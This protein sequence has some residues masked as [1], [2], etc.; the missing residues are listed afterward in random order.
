MWHNLV[1][2][3]IHAPSLGLNWVDL[4]CCILGDGS[5]SFDFMRVPGDFA[6]DIRTLPQKN[7]HFTPQ[8][9][10]ITTFEHG[11]LLLSCRML[12][13]H[14]KEEHLIGQSNIFSIGRLSFRESHL[15]RMPLGNSCRPESGKIGLSRYWRW[16]GIDDVVVLMM[17][18]YWRWRGIDDG[19]VLMMARYWRW[20]GID[21]GDAWIVKQLYWR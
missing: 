16:R 13:S 6:I 4:A 21:D 10:Q 3:T 15:Q 5:T 9:A 17:A 7:C 8:K 12:F 19:A 20:R 11:F 14:F 1:C 18:R 2:F